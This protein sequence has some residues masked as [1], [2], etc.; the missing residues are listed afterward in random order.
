MAG[1]LLCLLFVEQ[2]FGFAGFH[3]NVLLSS[4]RTTA[5]TASTR[6]FGPDNAPAFSN[7]QHPLGSMSLNIRIYSLFVASKSDQGE[8]IE[9]LLA[10]PSPV[11]APLQHKDIVWKIALPP[12]TPW[13]EKLKTKISA[14]LLRWDYQ[15]QG[16]D[17][18]L[19]QCPQTPN[20]QV[21]LEAY[22]GGK[23]V[24]RFG[25]SVSSGPSLPEI[26]ET[27]Q[28]L[29]GNVPVAGVRSA[30]IIYMFVEPEYRHRD[31]G[32]LALEVIALIH[33]YQ[34]CDF[35]VLVADDNGSGKLVDWYERKGNF[36]RAPKLQEPFG[37]PG[38]KLGITMIA[39]TNR[40]VPQDCCIQWW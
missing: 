19:V 40:T 26:E 23:K 1:I 20:Q 25:I 38:G 9:E 4:S 24:A 7:Q 30:A 13:F 15:R 18:P 12:E 17:P 32:R 39:P 16:V 28:E 37:S 22:L 36:R 3:S 6:M 14:N 2:V 11:S 35:T 21:V 29:Y 27:V 5:A 8:A 33:A 10:A 31:L 34:N